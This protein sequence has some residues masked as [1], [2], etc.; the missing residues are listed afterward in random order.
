MPD[1]QTTELLDRYLD[2]LLAPADAARFETALASD[3]ALSRKAA[4]GRRIDDAIARLFALPAADEPAPAPAPVA[5]RRAWG[6][7]RWMPLAAAATMALGAILLGS[8]PGPRPLSPF[9]SLY[10]SQRASGFVPEVPCETPDACRDWSLAKFG[11]PVRPRDG[12]AVTLAGWS[13]V[14][15]L[16]AYS[17]VLLAHADGREVVV[18]MDRAAEDRPLRL[19]ATGSGLNVFRVERGG[20]VLYEVSPLSR[21]VVTDSL[22]VG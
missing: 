1:L 2:G 4:L 13:Y 8:L 16:G 17:S 20:L 12:S 11:V 14:P 18:L 5:T 21:P 7:Q 6:R 9:E 15:A 10:A 22:D 19:P 3:A